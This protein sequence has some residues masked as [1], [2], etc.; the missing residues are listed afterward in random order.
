MPARTA[1]LMPTVA[2][3]W[4]MTHLHAAR[5]A[6]LD[7]VGTGTHELAHLASHLLR[8]VDD[9]RRSSGMRQREERHIRPAHHPRV[10]VTAGLAEDRDRD[11]H[12]G[13]WHEPAHLRLLHAE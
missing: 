13:P 5:R 9:V 11:Q 3:A 8:T 2:W 4:L 7:H 12:R 6:D 1:D 10:A